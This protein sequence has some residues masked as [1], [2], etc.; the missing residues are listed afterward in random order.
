[1]EC[2]GS[3]CPRVI[4]LDLEV[5]LTVFY[6]LRNHLTHFEYGCTSLDSQQQ[7][8]HAVFALHPQQNELCL[9]FLILALLTGVR[10]NLSNFDLQFPDDIKHSFKGFLTI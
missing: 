3:M 4:F 10:L 1:M 7:Q 2:F 8:K 6:F 9:V 5:E